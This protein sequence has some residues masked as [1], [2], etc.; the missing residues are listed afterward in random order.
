MTT[1]AGFLLQAMVLLALAGFLGFLGSRGREGRRQERDPAELVRSSRKLETGDG[2]V[3][4]RTGLK[5]EPRSLEELQREFEKVS[6]DLVKK[7]GGVF[8]IVDPLKPSAEVQAWLTGLSDGEIVILTKSL[9]LQKLEQSETTTFAKRSLMN[10]LA[11]AWGKVDPLGAL[12]FEEGCEGDDSLGILER[13]RA[14]V[15]NGWASQNPGAAW[16]HFE[17]VV[18][19]AEPGKIPEG[20]FGQEQS[21]HA[22]LAA[23]LGNLARESPAFVL[24]LFTEEGH[25]LGFNGQVWT[26]VITSLPDGSDWERIAWNVPG[27]G[28]FPAGNSIDLYLS[29]NG[30]ASSELFTR[31]ANE[32]PA[33]ALQWF[34]VNHKERHLGTA[35]LVGGWF[36][37]FPG[38]AASWIDQKLREGSAEFEAIS[39]KMAERGG[40]NGDSL[41]WSRNNP[42][43]Q[44]RYAIFK[45]AAEFGMPNDYPAG[46]PGWVSEG[47]NWY[48]RGD[49]FE[50]EFLERELPKFRL[51]AEQEGEIRQILRKRKEAERRPSELPS[52]E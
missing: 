49:P 33:K 39:W 42:D 40:V 34:E 26:S 5:R 3:G 16:R 4:T 25:D 22:T 23:I 10:C 48:V 8:Y 31:W 20:Y 27:D 29:V 21:Y 41:R 24:E 43:T 6:R 18:R 13:F 15:Y 35:Y 12:A 52:G 19:D 36:Q 1:R 37:S 51:T 30:W 14:S 9:F 7:N 11:A 17:P 38:Q 2:T 28:A 44:T 50:V 45:T 46:V 32:E 47:P